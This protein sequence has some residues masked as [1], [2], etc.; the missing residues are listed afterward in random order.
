MLFQAAN[1]LL[2]YNPALSLTSNELARFAH[3]LLAAAMLYGKIS[4]GQ[5]KKKQGIQIDKKNKT[6]LLDGSPLRLPKDSYDLLCVLYEHADKPCAR[7][8]VFEYVF[9]QKYDGTNESHDGR[10]YTAIRRLREKIE[11]DPSHPR[12]LLTDPRGYCLV[13]KPRD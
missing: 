4:Q 2:A 10:L 13:V 8:E 3:L 12:Y 5:E 7:N 11:I 1:R 6:V 9:K